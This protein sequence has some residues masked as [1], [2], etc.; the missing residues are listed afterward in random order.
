MTFSMT[1]SDS[2]EGGDQLTVTTSCAQLM[3]DLLVIAKFF[4]GKYF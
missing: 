3:H 1:L 4:V 2:F